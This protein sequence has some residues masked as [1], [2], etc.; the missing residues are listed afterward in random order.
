VGKLGDKV[1]DK[2][3]IENSGEYIS[4]YLRRPLRSLADALAERNA[5]SALAKQASRLRSTVEIRRGP[6]S[7]EELS[8]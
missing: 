7:F 8:A 5:T 3:K 1:V 2:I 6:K 4:P